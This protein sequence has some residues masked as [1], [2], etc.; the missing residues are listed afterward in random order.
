METERADAQADKSPV[1]NVLTWA[2]INKRLDQ[3]LVKLQHLKLPA[4]Q[5]PMVY[6][7]PR[8]GAIV[9]GLLHERHGIHIARTPEVADAFVD[10]I[11]DS[12]RTRTLHPGKP[13]L[14][15]VDKLKE[16]DLGWVHFPW[17]EHPTQDAESLVVRLL[18]FLG[19]DVHREGLR[20]TPKRV[21][22][23]WLELT[24]GMRENPAEVLGTKFK[25]DADEM[26]VCTGIEFHS[27]C[28][29]H[30]LPFT[31]TA[32]VA[33]IPEGEVYGLSKL[34][35]VVDTYARRLQIQEQMT[36]Q[37]AQAIGDNLEKCK[38]V[39]VHI[40]A[41]HQCMVC[42]GVRKQNSVMKTSALT[43]LFKADPAARAEFYSMLK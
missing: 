10:D 27:T 9:A 11:I 15:L 13:F 32:H 33:Y 22:K 30:L 4:D 31:G 18:E 24:Q 3:L 14:A 20:D 8:G 17:E 7:I 43:G 6:G 42:R 23:A 12:G 37:I 16:P 36:Q 2:D 19:E 29:H 1:I 28:E 41:K 25:S 35:R 5:T 38:G 21:I 34:A 26:V 39:A 40:E